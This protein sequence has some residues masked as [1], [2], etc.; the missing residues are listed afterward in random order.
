MKRLEVNPAE[1]AYLP[2]SNSARHA[3]M[4]DDPVEK[5]VLSTEL[6]IRGY[7]SA[8][9]LEVVLLTDERKKRAVEILE[10]TR[11]SF[12]ILGS[13]GKFEFQIPKVES[14]EKVE[15]IKMT[16]N[17]MLAAFNATYTD[18]KSGKLIVPKYDAVFAFQRGAAIVGANALRLLKKQPL[19]DV[20]PIHVMDYTPAQR[21][22]ACGRENIKKHAGEKQVVNHGPSLIK[23]CVDYRE[24]NGG[25]ITES[26]VC[27]LISPD[28][29]KVG[30]A[31]KIYAILA[32]DGRNPTLGIVNRILNG[33]FVKVGNREVD[34]GQEYFGSL[35]RDTVRKLEIG[36]RDGYSGSEP[37]TVANITEFFANPTGNKEEIVR[38][39]NKT[40]LE[41]VILR[42]A[43]P[44][45][46][47]VLRDVK[48]HRTDFI[49]LTANASLN[50][51]Y[52][53][54]VGLAKEGVLV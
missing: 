48:N 8:Q 13:E 24:A 19:L 17:D 21:V 30:M 35:D 7:D 53:E 42:C 3:T 28:V 25:K 41:E 5:A 31:Q 12:Q 52:L 36:S 15:R 40:E 9:P 20:I 6:F 26:K 11:K 50:S 47:Y 32:L 2:E 4:E 1:N 39:L 27:D 22:E 45:V 49:K 43:D 10:E 14:A 18:A 16:G 54:E 46:R 23:L 34:V 29:R 44:L 37:K 33:G 38:P 51:K